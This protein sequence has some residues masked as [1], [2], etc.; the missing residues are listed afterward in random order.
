MT[1]REHMETEVIR[2]LLKSYFDIVRTK[3]VDSVPKAVTLKLINRAESEMHDTLVGSLYKESIVSDLL[4]EV[5]VPD[6]KKKG[7]RERNERTRRKIGLPLNFLMIALTPTTLL[8]LFFS[9][10]FFP[11]FFSFF[12]FFSRARTQC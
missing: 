5:R 7:G 3:V 11:F 12:L 9:F 4:E 6:K 8:F 2:R 10:F 1:E